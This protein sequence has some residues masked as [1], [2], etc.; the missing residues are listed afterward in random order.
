MSNSE[1]NHSPA[2]YSG[3]LDAGRTYRQIS[4]NLIDGKLVSTYEWKDSLGNTG[5]TEIEVNPTTLEVHIN[6]PF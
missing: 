1:N 3:N 2:E 6:D 4:T 5:L